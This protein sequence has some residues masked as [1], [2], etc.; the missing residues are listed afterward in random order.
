LIEI[1]FAIQSHGIAYKGKSK[2]G[3]NS[4]GPDVKVNIFPEIGMMYCPF[5]GRCLEELIEEHFF[6]R[7]RLMA[8]PVF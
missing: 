8:A 2:K 4:K 3:Q 5:F 7:R 6:L 1:S